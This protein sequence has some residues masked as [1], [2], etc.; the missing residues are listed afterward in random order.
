MSTGLTSKQKL[1]YSII[2]TAGIVYAAYM[3][4]FSTTINNTRNI[5][6]ECARLQ[7]E[8]NELKPFIENRPLY[9][10]QI[11]N[12]NVE[13]KENVDSM[14]QTISN[15]DLIAY[16]QYL[17]DKFDMT[18]TIMTFSEP[19]IEE[20]ISY[21]FDQGRSDLELEER[22][23]SIDFSIKYN[24]LKDF[25]KNI[26]ESDIKPYMEQ[27]SMSLDTETGN[28]TGSI[29][30]NTRAIHGSIKEDSMYDV[31]NTRVGVNNIFGEYSENIVND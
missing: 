6:S 14:M 21:T 10:N 3:L 9:T 24:D 22:S 12:N 15:Q 18:S 7:T 17:E 26:E 8:L 2:L 31:S 20:K 23:A 16:N 28:I 29:S 30:F 11:N 19:K 27:I 5:E 4:V 13:I 1:V 25:L